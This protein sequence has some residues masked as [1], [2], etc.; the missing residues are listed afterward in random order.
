MAPT[1]IAPFATVSICQIWDAFSDR[2]SL[3]AL[4]RLVFVG[5]RLVKQYASRGERHGIAEAPWATDLGGE[6]LIMQVTMLVLVDC[7]VVG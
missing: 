5:A 2:V 7:M 4:D 3:R 6:R 1:A